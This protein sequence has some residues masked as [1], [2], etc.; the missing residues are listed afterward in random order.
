MTKGDIDKL[1]TRIG[2]SVKVSSEDLDK[3]QE[4]RQTYKEPIS[5]VFNY[6]LEVT[7]KIDKQCIVT[8]RIKRIDTIVEKLRRFKDNPNG[9]MKLSRMWDIA[10][11]RCIFNTSDTGKLYQLL[12]IISTNY[13]PSCKLNDYVE[14]PKPSGYRSIH[15]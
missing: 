7:R 9:E 8:Y 1:G 11:C 3:L 13:G 4:F 12:N 2:N 14:N 15:I 6:V 10:G 5:H